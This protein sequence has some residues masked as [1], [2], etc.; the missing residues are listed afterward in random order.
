MGSEIT[1]RGTRCG[2]RLA[3]VGLSV[4]F[5]PLLGQ[6]EPSL[7]LYVP[8][9]VTTARLF[10]YQLRDGAEVIDS[11]DHVLVRSRHPLGGLRFVHVMTESH[12]ESVAA[13]AVVA[14]RDQVARSVALQDTGDGSS[15]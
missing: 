4:E 13:P 9:V 12:L 7:A 5:A 11:V 2:R 15:A 3:A 8:A 10:S 1:Q 14:L 6:S